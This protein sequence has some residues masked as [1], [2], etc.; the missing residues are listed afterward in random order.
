MLH[1]REFA[2]S[3]IVSLDRN[4]LD[5]PMLCDSELRSND[6]RF[7]SWWV[8]LPIIDPSFLIVQRVYDIVNIFYLSLIFGS[9]EMLVRV[10]M[11]VEVIVLN[12]ADLTVGMVDLRTRHGYVIC[13]I[14][15]DT[16]SL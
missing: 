1:L 5:L 11:L 12:I 9:S 6:W 13:F 3:Y 10:Y 8:W 7:I 15:E 4:L 16:F 14:S 2:A